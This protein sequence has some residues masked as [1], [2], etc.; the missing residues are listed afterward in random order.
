MEQWRH[1]TALRIHQRQENNHPKNDVVLPQMMTM[2]TAM[3]WVVS[4]LRVLSWV[5]LL[6][7]SLVRITPRTT[8]TESVLTTKRVARNQKGYIGRTKNPASESDL[9]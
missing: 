2:M 8:V 3:I 5:L 9:H 7:L 4:Q 1:G 6:P